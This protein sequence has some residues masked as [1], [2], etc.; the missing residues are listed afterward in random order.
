MTGGVMINCNYIK[1]Q[2]TFP[3]LTEGRFMSQNSF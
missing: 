2:Q 3:L 1:T